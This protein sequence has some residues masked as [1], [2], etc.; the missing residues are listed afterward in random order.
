[1]KEFS[2]KIV[3][4]K[5]CLILFLLIGCK[6]RLN[7]DAS[8]FKNP[9]D[10]HNY[11]TVLSEKFISNGIFSKGG[12]D[13]IES[14]TWFYS[15]LSDTLAIYGEYIEGLPIKDW[16]F[17]FKGGYMLKSKWDAYYNDDKQTRLSLPF[18]FKEVVL[19]SNYFRL[20]TLNDSLG[21]VSIIIG[22]KNSTEYDFKIDS[23][24]IESES[25]LIQRGFSFTPIR[26]EI[27]FGSN[28][29]FSSEYNLIDST[30]IRSK[31]YN[32]YGLLPS[33]EKFVD[34]S[35]F[36]DGAKDEVVRII[37]NLIVS[38]LYIEGTRF[39]NPYTEYSESPFGL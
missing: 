11:T 18:K 38:H 14:G 29:Y 7:R 4:G 35:I 36:H 6:D 9:K 10:V 24:G 23:F 26:K 21:K 20:S 39:V 19:D 33:T 25:E 13:S 27:R 8:N 15:K 31:L 32:V 37:F 1:M 3:Y 34:F 17:A 2:C 16:T 22:V 12:V 28:T 5:Y 30:G